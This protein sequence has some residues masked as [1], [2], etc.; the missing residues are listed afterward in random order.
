MIK[1][2]SLSFFKAKFARQA[3]NRNTRRQG[4]GNLQSKVMRIWD[5]I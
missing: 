1:G 4:A 3:Y 5:T 2:V